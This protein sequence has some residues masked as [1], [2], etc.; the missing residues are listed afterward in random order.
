[1]RKKP[2]NKVVCDT[3][4][5]LANTQKYKVHCDNDSK[6]TFHQPLAKP[7]CKQ[8]MQARST[9]AHYVVTFETKSTCRRLTGKHE[10]LT[11]GT[12]ANESCKSPLTAVFN[13]RRRSPSNTLRETM[14]N[15]KSNKRRQKETNIYTQCLLITIHFRCQM[16]QKRP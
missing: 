4:I 8:T 10:R 5:W 9:N 3:T 2:L 12:A 16:T 7:V 11:V 13:R 15:Q 6:K 14:S 1:M